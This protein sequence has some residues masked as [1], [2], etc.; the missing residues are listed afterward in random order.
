MRASLARSYETL[1]VM[2]RRAFRLLG[3]FE[4]P[5]FAPWV[6]A[7]LLDVSQLRAEELMDTLV[8]QHLLEVARD[9]S[10]RLRY[11]FHDLLRAYAREV[12]AAQE[13][14]A[15]RLAALDRAFGGWLSLAEEAGRSMAGSAFAPPLEAGT[16]W[17]PDESVVAAVIADPAGWFTAECA[18]L[19]GAI[20][21]AYSVGSDQLGWALGVRLA[22]TFLLRGH[23]DDWRGVCELMLAGARRALDAGQG[24]MALS[25]ARELSRLQHRLDEALDG[26]DQTLTACGAG[27]GRA[28][29]TLVTGRITGGCDDSRFDETL[30]RLE[31]SLTYL[32]AL[33]DRHT[34]ACAVRRI[35]TV[36]RLQRCH[37][38]AARCFQQVLDALDVLSHPRK[39]V[40]LVPSGSAPSGSGRAVRLAALQGTPHAAW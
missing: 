19:V 34:D 18:G 39:E 2:A 22:R 40:A 36:H 30:P 35:R 12:A 13:C 26:F 17:R 29:A 10:G 28:V 38:K 1:D 5:D 32:R 25:D 8:D 21:Q 15:G 16:C 3:L 24:S 11:R 9:E 27:R 4:V 33:V 14:H 31:H 20:D 37:E 23:Y 7:A 6:T